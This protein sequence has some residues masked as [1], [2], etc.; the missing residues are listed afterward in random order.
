MKS[1][2]QNYFKAQGPFTNLSQHK[3]AISNL[4]ADVKVLTQVIQGLLMHDGFPK[5]YGLTHEAGLYHYV[6][7]LLDEVTANASHPI[8]IPRSPKERIQVCC[9]DY[10][11]LLTAF[12]RDRGIAARA[13][14]G[15]AKFSQEADKWFDHWLCEFWHE[16]ALEWIRVDAQ[17][18][19]HL[20][21]ILNIQYDPY[22][23][24]VGMFQVAANAWIAWRESKASPEDYV[25][26]DLSG[27]W[28]IRANLLRDFAALNKREIEPYMMRVNLG[29]NWDIWRLVAIDDEELTES[30]WMLLDKIAKL[31]L[32]PDDNLVDIRDLYEQEPGLQPPEDLYPRFSV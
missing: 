31:S 29:L 25:I 26:N 5:E 1:I 6:E 15:F 13:R 9:R 24:P 30:D 23:V 12:L 2:S 3:K 8:T 17:L 22:S 21:Q 14:C 18:N 10:A 7:D 4:S 32:N 28:L 20:Q 16:D 27:S 19:P 11:V